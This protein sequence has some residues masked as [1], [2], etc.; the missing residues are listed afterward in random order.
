MVILLLR[1]WLFSIVVVFVEYSLAFRSFVCYVLVFADAL[2]AIFT[3]QFR[4]VRLGIR[5]V[6]QTR[7]TESEMKSAK[8]RLNGNLGADTRV[9]HIV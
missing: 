9:A 7:A 4:L 3:K 1:F 8:I 5:A 6:I 2:F